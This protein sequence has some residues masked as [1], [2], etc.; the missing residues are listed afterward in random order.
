MN[1]TEFNTLAEA[2]LARLERALDE[3]GV[4][5]DYECQPGGVIEIEFPD[6]SRIVVN[7]HAA[8]REIW[9]AAK[10]GG[11]HFRYEDGRWLGT[12][13]GAELFAALG[14]LVGAQAGVAVN[15]G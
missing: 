8:A 9:V 15:L 7:R 13:D 1:E 2:A 14:R 6:A 12:R 3:C 4:D 5:I 11:F 10:A